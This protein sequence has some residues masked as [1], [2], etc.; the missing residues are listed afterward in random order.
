ME[1]YEPYISLG[2]ALLAGLLVGLERE[3]SRPPENEDTFFFGGIRTYPII[4]LVGAMGA[5]LH[6]DVGPLPLLVGGLGV[7]VLTGISYF[8]DS[9]E[10][11]AGITSEVSAL[12]TFFLGAFS[13][14]E[15]VIASI[16]TRV[17][18]VASVA[19]AS[20]LLLSARAELRTLTAK[21]SKEDVLATL[22]F[23]VVA[24]VVLPLL[25]S[26]DLGPYG[27]LNPFRIGVMVTMIA[28]V[29]FVGYVAIRWLGAGR[30]MLL[31]GAVGGFAS[32]TAVTLAASARAK[33]TP[34]LAPLSALSVIIASTVMFVRLLALLWVTSAELGRSL[35]IPMLVMAGVSAGFV[36][37]FYLRERKT[38]NDSGNVKLSNPFELLSALKFGA[39]FVVVLVASRWA[40][41]QFG[42]AGSYVTGALAGLTDVDAISLSMANQMKTGTVELPVADLTVVIATAANTIVKAGMSLV[43]GGRIMGLR[44]GLAFGVT[45][46]AGI[47]TVLVGR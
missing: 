20:T 35:A 9:S 46:I 10:G 31:T 25:P 21:L 45:L 44:V 28:G 27:A 47:V 14:A 34:E 15:G 39:F 16:Q 29:N 17:F 22:K 12:L 7:V 4:A 19:V 6:R 38:K 18:V 23:M 33:E 40:Q 13:V 3:Q 30:G 24:I 43:L 37:F 26:E 11:R 32:S 36:V 41:Q 5:L 2:L 42:S 1:H 8:R